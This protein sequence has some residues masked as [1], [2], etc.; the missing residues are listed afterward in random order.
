MYVSTFVIL[1][2]LSVFDAVSMHAGSWCGVKLFDLRLSSSLLCL[3][4][5][6]FLFLCNILS[7]PSEML[8]EFD[9]VSLL[10]RMDSVMTKIIFHSWVWVIF[11]S[12]MFFFLLEIQQTSGI[13]WYIIFLKYYWYS[14]SN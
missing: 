7:L 11:Y 9:F 1:L 8:S 2:Y 12:N 6:L 13:L 10:E 4:I 3:L 5:Y 14:C